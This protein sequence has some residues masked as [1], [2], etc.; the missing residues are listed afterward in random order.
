VYPTFS[1]GPP[2]F[3]FEA[4]TL[5]IYPVNPVPLET[6]IGLGSEPK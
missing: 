3:T 2:N 5:K 1:N 4:V 6:L